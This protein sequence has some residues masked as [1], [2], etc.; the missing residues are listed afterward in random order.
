MH[1][2][3]P[4]GTFAMGINL[5]IISSFPMEVHPLVKGWKRRNLRRGDVVW[6]ERAGDG[7]I[8]CAAVAAGMGQDSASRACAIA[9]ETLGSL[10]GLISLGFAGALSQALKPGVAYWVACVV[11]NET[12]ES[13]PAIHSFKSPASI[14]SM[15][16]LVTANHVAGRDEKRRIRQKYQAELID[17]EAAAVAREA[18]AHSCRFWC[19]KSV[20]DEADA[21]LPDFSVFRDVDGKLAQPRLAARLALQPRYWLTLARMGRNSRT[22]AAA[23]A[24]AVGEIFRQ[25]KIRQ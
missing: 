14:G 25:C 1:G 21:Q 22:G 20:S 24:A 12:G 5:G 23:M 15:L 2:S 11:D 6:R 18:A 3:A 17:M 9:L 13:F 10:D 7:S 16:T 8:D 19:I 4:M